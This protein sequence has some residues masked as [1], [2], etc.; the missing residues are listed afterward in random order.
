MGLYDRNYT[1]DRY[2]AGHYGRGQ[3]RLGIPSLT[4]VVKWL[5]IVN[6]SV[7]LLESIL[8]RM[9]GSIDPLSYWFSVFP[10]N[11]GFR[12][13]IWRLVTYQFIHAGIFHILMN[14]LGLYFL[15]PTLERYWGG[16]HFLGYYLG[17]GI[18]GGLLYILLTSLRVLLVG[19][20]VGASGAI[21][22]LLAACAIL[23]P[24]FVVFII[25]FPVPIRIATVVITIVALAAII[26]K[27]PNAGGQAAHF[28]GMLAG[29]A[30]IF[31]TSWRQQVL[32]KMQQGRWERKRAEQQRMEQ[33]L[34]D[35]LAKVS[36]HG[37]QSL[38][39]KEKQLLKQATEA[40]RQR[41]QKRF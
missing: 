1:Q 19:Q 25:V 27:G 7:F 6:F 34:D 26:G 37:L 41:N 11:W 12:L 40:E 5:L 24:Q 30:Y 14:M 4:P 32:G 15:G 13:Q 39:R 38:T 36:E 22:G 29:A 16:K 20:L 33:T 21:L 3:M 8:S 10:L 31:S 23:F 18:A 17:C 28:G 35:I 9:G 2:D